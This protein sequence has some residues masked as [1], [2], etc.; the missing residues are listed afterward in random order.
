MNPTNKEFLESM[1]IEIHEFFNELRQKYNMDV[2]YMGSFYFRTKSD[3]QTG[4]V[5]G[6]Y[7]GTDALANIASSFFMHP[8]FREQLLKRSLEYLYSEV[9]QEEEV[10]N[11][12]E[13][14]NMLKDIN[15]N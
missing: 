11:I 15:N 10:P 9:S 14:K 13:L 12:D 6:E 3:I 1:S 5:L 8:K 2:E 7:S 4:T